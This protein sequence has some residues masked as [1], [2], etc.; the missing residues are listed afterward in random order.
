MHLKVTSLDGIVFDGNV[1]KITLESVSWQIT[2][3]PNHD[4]L[5]TVLKPW[6]LKIERHENQ[7]QTDQVDLFF[8]D[9]MH[10][11][12]IWWWF[13]KV[14]NNYIQVMTDY[15]IVWNTDPID[16]LEDN[17]NQLKQKLD[18]LKA[19]WITTDQQELESLSIELEKIEWQIR[20]EVLKNV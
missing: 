10:I 14:E 8:K 3:L 13:C 19:S 5:L 2:I 9:N 4:N 1:N 12:S 20:L 7:D 6:L 11:I 15:S 18:D 17:K 16:I